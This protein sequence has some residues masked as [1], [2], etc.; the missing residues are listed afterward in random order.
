MR[1]LWHYRLWIWHTAW[2][3]LRHRYAG[4]SLGMF[5]NIVNPLA[6]LAVYVFILTQMLTPRLGSLGRDASGFALYLTCGFLPW[7]TFSDGIVRSAQTF[8]RN[9]AH[10]KKMAIPEIVFVAQTGMST[11][12]S[13]L[14]VD[15]L[16]VGLAVLLGQPIGWS[17]L[18]LPLIAV[19]WQGFG[20]G[21][22][23]TLSSINAFFRD[24]AQILTV[25]LQ[26]WM[27]SVP[28]IYLEEMLPAAYR[29][30]LPFNP[31]YPFVYALRAAVLQEAVPTWIYAAMCGWT[32]LALVTGR[33]VL[34]LL[35]TEIRDVL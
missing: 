3:D 13:M 26:I 5:W 15:V 30:T 19:V 10:L 11:L 22:G 32:A 17:W 16:L 1:D 28:V 35:Q 8:V 31:L 7:I 29:A 25:L 23:L 14:L 24:V 21:L 18:L 9:A 20:F 34:R 4:S 2:S 33:V 12:L 6:M 27:W